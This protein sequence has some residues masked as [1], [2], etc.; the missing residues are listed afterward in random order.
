MLYN[1]IFFFL[2]AIDLYLSY[3][4]WQSSK[5]LSE[6]TLAKDVE[7]PR[8]E[9]DVKEDGRSL[10]KQAQYLKFRNNYLIVYLLM[11]CISLPFIHSSNVKTLNVVATIALM[12]IDY[13]V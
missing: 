9:H 5:N 8:D 1:E 10:M 3:N 6:N 13:S 2:L 12:W 7:S 4:S 11:M